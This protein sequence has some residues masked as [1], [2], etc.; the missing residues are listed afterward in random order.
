M[1]G[2]FLGNQQGQN[3]RLLSLAVSFFY[4]C[5]I[6]QLRD[7]GS[8]LGLVPLMLASVYSGSHCAASFLRQRHRSLPSFIL[9]PSALG[10]PQVPSILQGLK[11]LFLLCYGEFSVDNIVLVQHCLIECL[12]RMTKKRWKRLNARIK[13]RPCLHF[14]LHLRDWTVPLCMS[15]RGSSTSSIHSGAF[16]PCHFRPEVHIKMY[17]FFFLVCF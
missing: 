8:C 7:R 16:P 2:L 17:L 14:F 15:S 10:C 3:V 6:M 9:F 12:L 5:F 13:R 11:S 4:Q 1:A